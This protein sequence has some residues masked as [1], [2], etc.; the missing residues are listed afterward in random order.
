MPRRSRGVDIASQAS[1]PAQLSDEPKP[2]TRRA[3]KRVSKLPATAKPTLASDINA[4]PPSTARRAPKRA[5]KIPAGIPPTS[6]PIAYAAASA[7][8]PLFESP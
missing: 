6:V 7:P 3:A 1:P 8:T 5:E 4:S 2:C